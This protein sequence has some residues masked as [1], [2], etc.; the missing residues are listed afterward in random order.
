VHAG[1][2]LGIAGVQGNGQTEL[3]EVLT[4]LRKMLSGTVKFEGTD[5]SNASPRRITEIGSAHVPEDRQADGLVLPFPVAENLVLCTYYK[6]P[7]SKGI[8]LQFDKILDNSEKLVE[9]FDI[10]TPSSLTPVG[11]LSGGNQQKVIIAREL[12]RPIK[13]LIA[14]QPTRGL[15]VGSIEYI[16]KRI[17]QKRDEGCA[18]LLVSPELDE[19]MELSDRIAVMYRGR[20]IAIVNAAS[21]SKETLGLLMAGIVPEKLE[22]EPQEGQ[23]VETTF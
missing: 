5:I 1:Q 14:S 6:E 17:I 12:S 2:V 15:D 19:I 22:K 10:R 20:I 18:V 4:G 21:V 8:T 9:D 23:V 16:H 7:F 11:S 13:L 3:V